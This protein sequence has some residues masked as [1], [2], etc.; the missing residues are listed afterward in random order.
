MNYDIGHVET[1]FEESSALYE[2]YLERV[3]ESESVN[4]LIS[5][6]HWYAD[7]FIGLLSHSQQR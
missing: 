4:D 7:A 5:A 6:S 3:F 1:F 2:Y